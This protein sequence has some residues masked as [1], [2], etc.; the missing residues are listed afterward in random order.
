VILLTV[1][2][3]SVT[4]SLLSM[5][6]IS[7]AE[8]SLRADSNADDLER[9]ETG[10]RSG[11]EWA[12]AVLKRSGPLATFS[13]TTTLDTGVVVNAQL[14]LLGS[15]RLVGRGSCNGVE[16]TVG[17]DAQDIEP[18]RPYALM[19]FADT[20]ASTTP[21][22]LDGLAY[23]GEPGTPLKAGSVLQMADDLDL[24]T[25]TPLTAGQVV[26]TG[27]ATNYGVASVNAPAW[28]T[29]PYS[30]PGTWTVPYRSVSGTTTIKDQTINGLVVATLAAGQTL[31]LDNVILNGT[32]VVPWAYPPVLELLGTPTIELKGATI[33]GGTAQTGNLAILAP[34]S[35]L[36]GN[37]STSGSISGVSYVRE[38]DGL[39]SFTAS[40]KV[41]V[42]KALT[43]N[44]GHTVTFQRAASFVPDVP[45]GIDW[46]SSKFLI[47][48]LG[49]Q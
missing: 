24:V 9:A 4:I 2:I 16:V 20:N 10:A 26:R 15:P 41:L 23:L 38:L 37:S 42:R 30:V 12:A 29:T 25:T 6:L 21:I 35:L 34:G 13:G 3:L 11:V 33:V 14:R 47:R 1:L 36:Q 32:L 43:G 22:T 8:M 27:G 31:T 44:S 28:D 49:R 17:G 39:R 5:A 19:S 18:T 7:T 40:G 48:W 45:V 46:G